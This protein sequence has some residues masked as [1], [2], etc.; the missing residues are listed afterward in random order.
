MRKLLIRSLYPLRLLILLATGG[1]TLLTWS[2]EGEKEHIAEAVNEND[3]LP[4]M[5]SRGISNLIS[6]SGVIRYKVVAEEWDIYNNTQ[7]PKWVFIKGILLEKFDSTFHTDWFV[8]SDTAY[9]YN[10]RLWELRGR[11][12]VRNL[13]G[14]LFRTEELFWDMSSHEIYSHLF[15]DIITPDKQLKAYNFT[16]DEQM[17]RYTFNNAAGY[18]PLNDSESTPDSTRTAPAKP[19]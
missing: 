5:H 1:L 7:P 2:C 18:M 16:A 19:Q 8:Q 4:F 6:D 14:T 12:V 10:Q 9:C 15:V 11:V 13:Q 3:S 17:T